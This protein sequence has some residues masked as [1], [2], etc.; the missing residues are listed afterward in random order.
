MLKTCRFS[1]GSRIFRSKK[2]GSF[3]EKQPSPVLEELGYRM[4]EATG[5]FHIAVRRGVDLWRLLLRFRKSCEY[6]KSSKSLDH[7]LILAMVF[8]YHH[9]RTLEYLGC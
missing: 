5:R 1:R 6:P 4:A 2:R 3:I 8:G 9:F 7:D